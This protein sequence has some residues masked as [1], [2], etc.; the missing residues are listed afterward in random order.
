ML[1][2]P[3]RAT[4][5]LGSAAISRL[6]FRTLPYPDTGLEKAVFRV[7]TALA[8]QPNVVLM[9]LSAHDL[10]VFRGDPSPP[11]LT[12]PEGSAGLS[13][14]VLGLAVQLRGASQRH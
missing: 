14:A 2:V 13:A 4:A 11:T 3:A 8:L 5:L 6:T 1:N 12:A 9:A 7:D 10:E